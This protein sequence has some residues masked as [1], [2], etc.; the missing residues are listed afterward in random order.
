MCVGC[1]RALL[2]KIFVPPG[3]T[4]SKMDKFYMKMGVLKPFESNHFV[5]LVSK[6]SK[7]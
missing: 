4:L 5:W 2:G 1:H 7:N 3:S 6:F